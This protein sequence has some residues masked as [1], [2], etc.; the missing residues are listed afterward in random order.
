M[1]RLK[2][3]L[4]RTD[5]KTAAQLHRHTHRTRVSCFRP[6]MPSSSRRLIFEQL[7]SRTLLSVGGGYTNAGILGEYYASAAALPGTPVSAAYGS[8]A[9]TRQD[10]RIDF[11]WGTTGQPGG[12]PDPAYASVSRN[13][14][15]V[16]WTGELIP[17]FSQTY[18]FTATTVGGDML[19]IRPHGVSTWTTL[20]D[21]WTIHA[22]TADSATYALIAGQ[23]YDIDFEYRQPTAG[24]AT[25]CKLHWSSPSTPDEAIEPATALGVGFDGGD[26]TFANMVNAGTRAYWW[27]PGFADTSDYVATDSNSWPEA[28]AEIYLGEGDPSMEEG[29]SYLVQFN[30]TAQLTDW[31]QSV[32]FW[33]NG[34]NYGST[35][36]PGDG[37]NS[38]TNTTTVTMV[39][40]PDQISDGGF[41]MTFANTSRDGKVSNPEHNGITN[42]Y[43]M[44][45]ATYAG[46]TDPQPGTLFTQAALGEAA[47]YTTLRLMDFTDTNGNLTSNWSDRTV[48]GDNIWTGWQF[49]G[50]SGVETGNTT[51]YHDAGIPWEVCVALGNETGKDLYI[52]IPSNASIEYIE[53]LADLFAYGSNGV[54]PYTSPQ[55]NPVWPPLDSNL[56]VIIEFSNEIWNS[57]V[58]FGQSGVATSGWSNQLSQRAVYDYLTDNQNDPLYPGGGANAYND[59]AILAPQYI[60]SANE[61]GFLATYT[62]DPTPDTPND[63]WSSP[64]YFSNADSSVNGY[65]IYQGWVALRL[66]QISMAFKAALGDTGVFANAT[67]SRAGR[68]SSGNM[69]APTGW[70]N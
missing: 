57:A 53:N 60:T 21:D 63:T 41:W 19:Y 17:N 45:P 1:R 46:S 22:A 11:N 69:A 28:D 2:E 37:Y 23:T 62:A 18:T 30:G 36:Y 51:T 8:P 42:L 64:E 12:S 65:D 70:A 68:S 31:P 38:A 6:G 49:L 7:E 61:A 56:K 50:G 25:E 35:L 4:F 32:Q 5:F 43:V 9:F 27:V 59:G 34:V 40:S 29:G 54:T 20:I 66:E 26:A 55:A 48:P 3:Y 15:S 67:A 44:Q 24:V 10:V 39:V 58:G 47:Q 14:F 52:N 13:N 16:L 33:A